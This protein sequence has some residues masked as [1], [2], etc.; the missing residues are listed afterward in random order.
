MR[1]TRRIVF[2]YE[3]DGRAHRSSRLSVDGLGLWSEERASID[4]V[5]ARFPPG[6]EVEVRYSPN[7][8]TVAFIDAGLGDRDVFLLQLFT[9]IAVVLALLAIGSAVRLR[10]RD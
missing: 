10:S 6:T 7:D 1:P 4:E 3:A 5:V 9:A 2:S 8:A